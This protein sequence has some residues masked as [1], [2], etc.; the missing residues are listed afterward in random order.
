MTTWNPA[1][2]FHRT[3]A[4]ERASHLM[5]DELAD[6]I[7]APEHAASGPGWNAAAQKEAIS[8]P[9]VEINHATH[10][11][12]GTVSVFASRAWITESGETLP[13]DDEQ[14]IYYFAF[15]EQGEIHD[16]TYETIHQRQTPENA[17]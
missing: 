7:I 13:I 11:E 4:E 3:A 16:Y 9:H 17:N 1:S 15:N 12:P 6:K 5:T 2:D 8:A 10:T 14:R